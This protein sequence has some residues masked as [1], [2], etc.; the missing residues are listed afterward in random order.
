MKFWDRWD[1]IKTHTFAGRRFHV[2]IDS[3]DGLCEKEESNETPNLFIN[4]ARPDRTILEAATHEAMHACFPT[5]SELRVTQSAND[6]ARLLWR[7]GYR[8]GD[9]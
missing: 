4:A 5:M 8:L 6:I 1:R 2:I 3:V 9:K 7:M